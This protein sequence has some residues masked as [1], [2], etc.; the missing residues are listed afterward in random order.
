MKI[1]SIFTKSPKYHRFEY[2]PRYYDPKKEEHDARI[3]RIKQEIANEKG[4][5]VAQNNP[6]D[7]R[8]RMSGAFQ[9]ARRKAKPQ[10]ELDVALVRLFIMLAIALFLI[11]FLTWGKAAIYGLFLVPPIWIYFRFFRKTKE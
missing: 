10:S 6:Y 7:Y 3:E 9:Q 4:D 5:T 2:K 8:A 11:A 1:P